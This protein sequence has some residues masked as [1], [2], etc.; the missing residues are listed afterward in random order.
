MDIYTPI[1]AAK[2][3][4]WR[5]WTDA[6]LRERVKEYLNGDI[7]AVFQVEPMGVLDR[8]II[9]PDIE[10]SSF[11]EL[12]SIAKIKPL[13]CE[14]LEDKFC[15]C[16]T[17]KLGLTKLAF[18]QGKN[19]KGEVILSY[20]TVVDC[21]H[22]DGKQFSDI[23]TLWGEDLVTFHH[24]IL[25]LKG[26]KI[27]IFDLSS[28]YKSHGKSAAGYYRN[29]LALFVCNGIL[30]EN[31]VTDDSESEFAD[32]VV[33]PAV[34]ELEIKFGLKPLVVP[35][36][37]PDEASDKYW[38]CYPAQIEEEVLNCLKLVGSRQK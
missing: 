32:R 3:E 20:R 7:P 18:F 11:L 15:S 14:Y 27:N 23:K 26:P 28:W 22:Y 13:G 8:N 33:I 1:E 17:D 19:K 25:A 35:L 31:F 4:I 6:S 21:G 10:F 12:S 2:E 24:R 38:W 34:R 5:R 36:A 16:N 9:S 37:P 29:F 30:F